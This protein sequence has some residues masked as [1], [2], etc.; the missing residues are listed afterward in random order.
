MKKQ[1]ALFVGFI[2]VFF[3]VCYILMGQRFDPLARYPYATEENHDKI[4]NA[5]SK[6]DIQVLVDYDIR[7]EEFL[8]FVKVND[9][10]LRN[11]KA[12]YAASLV[13]ELPKEEI[14][15]NVN[16]ILGHM[17]METMLL[18]LD[19]Y[20]FEEIV[21]W[22]ENKDVYNKNSIFIYRPTN[23]D[24]ILNEVYTVGR[25]VP[26]DLEVVEALS[27]LI[28]NGQIQLRK[29]AN[30]ALGNMCSL[31]QS[32]FNET[33]GGLIAREGFMSYE[34][35]MEAYDAYLLKYGPDD[36]QEYFLFPGHNEWQLGNS[37]EV[38]VKDDVAFVDSE[39]Y[40]WLLKHASEYGFVF[41]YPNSNVLRY[42]G[43]D[44]AIYLDMN[45]MILEDVWVNK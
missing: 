45:D 36:V 22:L 44:L 19:D 4:L 34:E 13:K 42:V 29:E 8:P 9:F 31:L 6:A 43:S 25:Y 12:Y 2:T 3:I 26:K 41:R 1:R 7:P 15:S 40:A 21:D 17:S 39:Q 14:V 11:A 5:V 28:S 24:S 37:L 35:Q 32:E 38:T 33:C 10:D 27:T 20:S 16:F 18:Y 30:E 23:Y